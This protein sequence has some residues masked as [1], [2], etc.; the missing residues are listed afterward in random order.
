M[1]VFLPPSEGKVAP[2]HRA[3]SRLNLDALALPHVRDQRLQVLHALIEASGRDDAQQVLKVGSSV[4]GEVEA[5]RRLL[6]AAAAPAHQIYTGVLF[7]ALEAHSLSAAKLQRAA[8]HV[9]IF[10]ALFGVTKLTDEIPAHRLSMGVGLSP[11]GDDRDPGRLGGFWRSALD[12]DLRET[13]GD[14]LVI[15]CRSA[16]Y[17]AAFKPAPKQTLVVNS[18]TEN[19]GQRKVVT[20]FA[21]QARGLLAGMLL[22]QPQLPS[23]MDEV[24]EIASAHWEVELRESTGKTPNQLD[25]IQLAE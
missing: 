11:F 5:N 25:L 10:S 6:T 21:K 22:R 4:M 19:K 18:F 3:D 23:T 8:D 16:A 7:E 17:A 14:Q 9:L 20:H 13:I 24:A 15:D 2:A 12:G 1:F